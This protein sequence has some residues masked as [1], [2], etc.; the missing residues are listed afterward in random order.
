MSDPI[1]GPL[2]HN[3]VDEKQDQ[4]NNEK[5]KYV[6]VEENKDGK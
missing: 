4:V 1:C 3:F 6:F 2:I 5:E